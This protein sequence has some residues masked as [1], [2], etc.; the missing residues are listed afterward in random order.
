MYCQFHHSPVEI[1]DGISWVTRTPH[2]LAET[3]L[4]MP[5]LKMVV[6]QGIE[7]RLSEEPRF[8]VLWPSLDL[9]RT[10]ALGAGLEPATTSLTV[11]RTTIVLP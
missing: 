2:F 9:Y 5:P 10:M 8:T 4:P 6:R 7:P 3:S 1:V 11:R